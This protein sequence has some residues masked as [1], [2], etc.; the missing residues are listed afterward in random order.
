MEPIRCLLR[1]SG[2]IVLG[3]NK[4]LYTI[5]ILVF[6]WSGK[7]DRK[8]ARIVINTILADF[9]TSGILNVFTCSARFTFYFIAW[10]PNNDYKNIVIF[11][12]RSFDVCSKVW[13]VEKSIPNS[14]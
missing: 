11:A 14:I 2:E 9:V 5:A 13:Y 1:E 8:I 10:C 3:V 4:Y 12:R 6:F 7:S